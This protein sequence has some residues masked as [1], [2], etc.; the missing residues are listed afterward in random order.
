MKIKHEC[1]PCIV[2]Q[3]VEVAHMTTQNN[4][5]REQII[6]NAAKVVSEASFDETA[7]YLAMLVHK[8]AN[9]N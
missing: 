2:R 1:M 8:F 4:E 6:R 7:V 5:L 3:S 9:F